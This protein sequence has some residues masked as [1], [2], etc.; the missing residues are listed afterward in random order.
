MYSEILCGFWLQLGS[1]YNRFGS[2][3]KSIKL[4]NANNG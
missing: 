3:D 4:Y 2:Y 1:E